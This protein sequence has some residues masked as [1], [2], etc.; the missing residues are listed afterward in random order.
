MK[1]TIEG[2]LNLLTEEDNSMQYDPYSDENNNVKYYHDPKVRYG[3]DWSE[4]GGNFAVERNGNVYYVS[5]SITVSLYSFCKNRQGNW[6]ILAN[7]R[8]KGANGANGKWNVSCGYLDYNETAESGAQRETYEET[9]VK[10]PYNKI[11]MKHVNSAG[12]INKNILSSYDDINTE[13]GKIGK[14]TKADK[15][16]NVNIR[17]TA[18]LNGVIDNYPIDIS[19]CEPGEVSNAKWIPLDEIGKYIWAFGQGN[20]ILSQAEDSIGRQ[21]FKNNRNN[22]VSMISNLKK[23]IGNNQRAQTLLKNILKKTKNQ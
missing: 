18:V 16:Q 19:H 3:K 13:I 4:H 11:K 21:Y 9:G 5:R 22:I 14:D 17:F 6:C 2:L 10:I 1:N 20:S 23:E 15:S 12:G 8:G 7:Q